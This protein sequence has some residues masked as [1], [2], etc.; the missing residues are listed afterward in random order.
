MSVDEPADQSAVGSW[1]NVISAATVRSAAA[2]T[3]RSAAAA[4]S[5]VDNL[6]IDNMDD[7]PNIQ[8]SDSVPQLSK[9]LIEFLLTRQ[10]TLNHML[11]TYH[12]LRSGSSVTNATEKLPLYS[13]SR[14]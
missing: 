11:H 2:A 13:S 12:S 8:S 14:P 6:T 9:S 7:L 10:V 1:P 4:L 3:V 5:P